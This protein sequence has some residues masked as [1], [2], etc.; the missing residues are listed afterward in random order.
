MADLTSS[1]VLVDLGCGEGGVVVHAARLTGAECVGFDVRRPCVE[2]TQDAA[3]SEGVSHLVAA[4]EQDFFEQDALA[5]HPGWRRS[6]VVYIY[7]MPDVVR[8]LEPLLRRAVDDGKV[9]VIFCSSGSRARRDSSRPA[10]NVIGDL[11]PAG[12][13]MMGKLRLYCN[14]NVL[15]RRSEMRRACGMFTFGPRVLGRAL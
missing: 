15:E 9:V 14:A 13:A 10:G 4:V 2:K 3:R 7:L 8:R 11:A 6:S 1:D 5:G 12:Q